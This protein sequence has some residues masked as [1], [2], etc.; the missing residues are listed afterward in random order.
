[1]ATWV[2]L[3]TLYVQKSGGTIN[4]ALTVTGKVT[5]SGGLTVTYNSTDYDIGSQIATLNTNVANAQKY[6]ARGTASTASA[7]SSAATY[8]YIRTT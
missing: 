6:I 7:M 1:M 4:G 8:I 2:D 3:N 5:A